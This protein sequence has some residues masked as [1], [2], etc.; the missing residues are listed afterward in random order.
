[1]TDESPSQHDH[2]GSRWEPTDVAP[3]PFP[4]PEEVPADRARRAPLGRAKVALAAG[5]LALLGVAGAGGFAIG[6]A[7]AGDGGGA[8]DGS[9]VVDRD[10]VRDDFPGTPPDGDGDGPPGTLPGAGTGSDT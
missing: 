3:E 6:H 9:S 5:A 7:A 8:G 4:S 10:G 1:M 2:S